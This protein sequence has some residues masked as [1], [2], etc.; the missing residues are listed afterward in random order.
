MDSLKAVLTTAAAVALTLVVAVAVTN[1]LQSANP[2]VKSIALA[3]AG[4]SKAKAETPLSVVKY[5]VY[6]VYEGGGWALS[7][8][9]SAVSTPQ[10]YAVG[11]GNCP[12]DISGLY[13]RAY[14]PG[15]NVVHVTGC[16]IVVPSIAKEDGAVAITHYL[17]MCVS[18]TDF[19]TETVGQY[20][21]YKGVRFRVRLVIIRC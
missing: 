19:R 15:S 16:S 4:E 7:A 5:G 3:V 6:Y 1:A 8:A 18:G 21:T 14:A 13:G 20:F 12:A 11:F 10:L 17:P 9:P 2:V